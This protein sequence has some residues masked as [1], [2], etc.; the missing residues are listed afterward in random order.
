MKKAKNSRSGGVCITRK[1]IT[2]RRDI[3]E[4]AQAFADRHFGGNL[5]AFFASRI[6][7]DNLCGQCHVREAGH[8]GEL[9]AEASKKSGVDLSKEISRLAD[10]FKPP[11]HAQKREL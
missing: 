9:A 10:E 7:H 8:V 5:S 6:M 1:T 2:I 4:L 11:I 3:L